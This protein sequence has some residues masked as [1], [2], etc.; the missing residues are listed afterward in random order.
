VEW[1]AAIWT[2]AVGFIGQQGF[3]Y[4]LRL[5]LRGKH[6]CMRLPQQSIWNNGYKLDTPYTREK[7]WCCMYR[8]NIL[9]SKLFIRNM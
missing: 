4:T 7:Y 2:K 9:I 6:V 8:S 3:L 5:Y 1:V